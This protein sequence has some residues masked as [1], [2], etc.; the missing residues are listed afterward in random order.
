MGLVFMVA[1][2][3]LLMS[4]EQRWSTLS[5]EGSEPRQFPHS[6]F[7]AWGGKQGWC[8]AMG[9]LRKGLR[10]DPSESREVSLWL[11]Y[12]TPLSLR[13]MESPYAG[14]SAGLTRDRPQ[15]VYLEEHFLAS[16]W[17]FR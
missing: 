16:P 2:G 12:S 5:C 1:L 7:T 4:L 3:A 6:S 15:V 10:S 9:E 13:A 8:A 17:L 11:T 14:H